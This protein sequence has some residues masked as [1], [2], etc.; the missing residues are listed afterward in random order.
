M[1]NEQFS[2]SIQML[3]TR[4]PFD[5]QGIIFWVNRLEIKESEVFRENG[6]EHIAWFSKL[7]FG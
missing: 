3:R 1:E 4:L 7:L 2:V 5:S 6:L